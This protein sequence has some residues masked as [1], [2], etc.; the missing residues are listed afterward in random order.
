MGLKT[1]T[2]QT[3]RAAPATVSSAPISLNWNAQGR[4]TS[5]KNQGGCGS[6]WAFASTAYAESKM[7]IDD[8]YKEIDLAEQKLLQ[9]TSNSSCD[10]GYLEYAMDSVVSTI[11]FEAIFHYSPAF[12]YPVICS[13]M[14]VEI[15]KTAESYYN[16]TDDQIIALLQE[17]PVAVAVSATGWENY[18]SGVFKCGATD[19]I[20]HAVLLVGY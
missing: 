15:G 13:F 2:N 5:V 8:R 17:R 9:C 12:E 14:G 18:G 3:G 7:L 10:G 1:L 20:N 16:L 11:P 4:T 19:S 6:C